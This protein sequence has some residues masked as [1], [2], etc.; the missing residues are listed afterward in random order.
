MRHH[1][2][3]AMGMSGSM[4]GGWVPQVGL[5]ASRIE[6]AH[7]LTG[8]SRATGNLTPPEALH[9]GVLRSPMAH[10][11]LDG[12]DVSA[13]LAAPGVVAAFTGAD[14]APSWVEPLPISAPEGAHMP[15]QWPLA[16]GKVRFVGE[17][18]AVVLAESAAAVVDALEGVEVDYGPLPA[19]VSIEVALEDRSLLHEEAGT[20]LAYTYEGARV[21]DLDVAFAAADVVLERRYRQSRVMAVAL[22]PRS[23]LAEPARDAGLVL[24]TSTQV[25]H[26]IKSHVALVLGREPD[27]IRVVA[28]DVGG[29]F[30]PKLDCYAEEILC[31]EL[32]LRLGRP[33]VFTATRTE[34]LQSTSHGRGPIYDV[35]IGG[36][37]DGTLTGLQVAMIGDCGAYL[38]R[39]GANV[40]LNGE[41]VTPGCYRWMAYRFDA[42]GVFTTSV[43]TAPYRGAGRPE[44]IYAVERAIDDLADALKLDPAEVRRRN[45]PSPEEFPFP[46]IGG[47]VYDS[48]DYREGLDTALQ[49]VDHASWRAEQARRRT[50]G[51]TRLLGI[52]ISS[53]VDRCGT[54]PGMS[55]YGAVRVDRAG[56]VE[57]SS[58]LGPTGQGTATSLAQI[59][60]DRLRV[61]LDAITVVAGDTAR[62]P[63]GKG[64]FGS[65]SMSVGGV[66]VARA[67]QQV[68]ID[69]RRAASVLIEVDEEDLEL[70]EGGVGVRGAPETR[71][72]L[73]H[74]V[75]AVEDGQVAGLAR[76][77][78]ADDHEPEGL[79]YPSGTHVAVVEVDTETGHVELLRF[80][81]VDD[82]GEVINPA[83]LEGQLHGG[84]AQGIGQALYE[85]VVHDDEGNLLTSSLIDYHVPTAAD[86]PDLELHR[87]VT[88]GRNELGTKGGGE[89]GTIGAPPAVINAVVDALRELGVE[90]VQMPATP[91]RVWRAIQEA[92][93]TRPGGR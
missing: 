39:M 33:I 73:A 63:R 11:R 31:A 76:L 17:P 19:V 44:A 8:G 49:A 7:L 58:G 13:A 80:V 24:R 20:N 62:V 38:S 77:E 60:A 26:R 91:Q 85:G 15:P 56:R 69:A 72:E 84:V 93:R 32:A 43:P 53:Y 90:D 78:A 66:A 18:V 40:H 86:L 82:V 51:A 28:E 65:R 74:I 34:D 75:A 3:P 1:E 70:S 41:K 48:G 52:G 55:E 23:V 4:V 21:G 87:T 57:V 25:P 89:S 79:T 2:R 5:P 12:I 83:L 64:T 37:A 30:G 45:F 92:R 71:V 9:L 46:S 54:G 6:D 36:R 81:A 88:R 68:A 14:L 35:T 22:E 27:T 29:G 42:K 50:E 61:D 67:A 59:V 10:A 47:L 16:V